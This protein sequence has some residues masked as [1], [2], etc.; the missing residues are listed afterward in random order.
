MRNVYSKLTVA[1]VVV[2]WAT[3]AAT[4]DAADPSS[5]ATP[6]SSVS[7][8]NLRVLVPV[9]G[10]DL[11]SVRGGGGVSGSG[12]NATAGQTVEAIPTPTAFHAGLVALTGAVA[13]QFTRRR[14][15]AA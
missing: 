4:V 13:Y 1:A 15:R 11:P 7:E 9:D 3:T 12:V 5:Y 6:L 14:R 10:T 2:G 8:G